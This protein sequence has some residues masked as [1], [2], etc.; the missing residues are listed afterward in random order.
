M[1]EPGGIRGT[2]EIVEPTRGERTIARRAA[3]S[4]ATVPDLTL[5]SE[6]E[7]TA[8]LA[9]IDERSPS[10]TAVLVRAA[11]LALRAHPRANAAYRDGHFELYSRVNAGV[12]VTSGEAATV[13]DADK[14]S[15]QELASEIDN[16]E[17]RGSELTSPELSGATFTIARYAVTR[18]DALI[19]PPHAVSLAAGE[20]REGVAMRDGE[21][22]AAAVLTLT[23]AC[24]HRILYGERAAAVLG[25]IRRL[26]EGAEL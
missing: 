3:E 25:E 7:M 17:R 8:A 23:M 4:R 22:Q 16:L 19:T 5:A 10:L 2:V 20:V 14:K 18:A 24:D 11:A 12:V 21:L 26:L 13:L 15:L 6:V 1:S 9:L